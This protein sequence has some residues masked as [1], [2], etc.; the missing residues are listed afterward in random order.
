MNNNSEPK[1]EQKHICLNDL[2]N[3]LDTQVEKLECLVGK[4]E[5]SNEPPSSS[6]VEP[7]VYTPSL[8]AFLTESVGRME[9]FIVRLGNA[10]DQLQEL[11]F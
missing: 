5:G 11:L 2:I 8:A 6:S 10:R 3:Q 1:R 9:N 4:I 7:A